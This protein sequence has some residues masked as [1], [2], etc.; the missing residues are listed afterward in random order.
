M[1]DSMPIKCHVSSAIPY[2]T[3]NLVT[4]CVIADVVVPDNKLSGI[5][6]LAYY[7]FN[8][9]CQLFLFQLGLVDIVNADPLTL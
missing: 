9:F 3:H 2:T 4:L 5:T 7:C 6:L 8:Y 1:S